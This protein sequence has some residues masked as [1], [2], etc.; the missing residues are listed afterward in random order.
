ME[1]IYS[2]DIMPVRLVTR[3]EWCSKLC[4]V[5]WPYYYDAVCVQVGEPKS[6]D[7]ILNQCRVDHDNPCIHYQL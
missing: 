7:L 1:V 6:L 5:Y 3:L 4:S 2:V